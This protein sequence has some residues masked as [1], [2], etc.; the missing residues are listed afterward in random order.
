MGVEGEER[1][2]AWLESMF[3]SDFF[4]SGEFSSPGSSDEV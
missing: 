3:D 1:F 4:S 2:D